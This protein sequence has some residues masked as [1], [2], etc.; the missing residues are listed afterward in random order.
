MR[1]QK[2]MSLIEVL[3]ALFLCSIVILAAITFISTSFKNTSRNKDKDFATQKAIAMLEE[4][5]SI[6]ESQGDDTTLLDSYDDGAVESEFLTIRRDVT[7]PLDPASGNVTFPAINPSQPGFKYLRRIMVQRLPGAQSSSIRLVNVKVFVNKDDDKD[8]DPDLLAEVAGVIQTV[9][10]NFP[11]TQVY[12]VYLLALENVPGWWVYMSN[13]IPFVQNAMADLQARNPGLEFRPHWITKLSY[14]RD[15]EYVPYVNRTASS[16]AASSGN[17]VY[18]YPGLMPGGSSVQFYYPPT[19]FNA[20]VAVDGVVTNGYNLTANPHPYALAD[21]FN[22]AMRYPDE[23]A[24]FENRVAA[25]QEVDGTPTFR[26]LLERMATRPADFRNAIFINLH[27]E[28][29]PFPPIRNYSDPAKEPVTFPNVRVVTHSERLRYRNDDTLNLRVYGYNTNAP[30]DENNPAGGAGAPGSIPAPVDGVDILSN[31]PITITIKGLTA[32]WVPAGIAGDQIQAIKGG[33]DLEAPLNQ[34]DP[35][36]LIVA[37]TTPAATAYYTVDNSGP[38]VVIELFNTPLRTPAWAIANQDATCSGAVG[39]FNCWQG[40]RNGKRLYGMEYIPSP[41]EDFT[42]DTTATPVPGTT[43]PVPT[44]TP[45]TKNLTTVESATAGA[46][47]TRGN[48]A[49]NTARWIF[50]IPDTVLPDDN[51]ITIETR[52]G[53]DPCTGLLYA[54]P[55][56]PGCTTIPNE[57]TNLSRTYAWRGDDAHIFGD[58]AVS[59]VIDP[60]LPY[61]ERY[62]I[63]GDPRHLPYVDSKQPH[64]SASFVLHNEDSLGMGYNRYFDDFHMGTNNCAVGL[65]TAGANCNAAPNTINDFWPGWTYTIGGQQYGLKSDANNNNDGW[66]TRA[67]KAPNPGLTTNS[68]LEIDEHRIFQTYRSILMKVQSVYTT[69]SGFSYYYTGI[70]NEI[71]YDTANGFPNSIP[72]NTKPFTGVA[73]TGF[74]DSITG[75]V[76]YIREGANG[77]GSNYWWG[78]SWLG[79]LWP[80]SMYPSTAPGGGWVTTGNLPT[81][82]TASTFVRTNRAQT[83]ATVNN[84]SR[85]RYPDGTDLT[86]AVRRPQEEGSATFF[87]TGSANSTFHHEFRDNTFGT[88]LQAGTDIGTGFNYPIPDNV[89]LYRPFSITYNQ[90]NYN[91]NAFLQTVYGPA[92]TTVNELQFYSHAGPTL[93]S[94]LI[95]VDNPTNNDLSFVVVNGLSMT[96]ASGTAFISRW[97]MLSLIESFLR[98][99][100]YNISGSTPGPN[101]I[102]QVPRIAITQPS[103]SMDPDLVNDPSDLEIIWNAEWLRWN[104]DKYIEGTAS[105]YPAGYAENGSDLTFFVLWTNDPNGGLGTWKYANDNTTVATPGVRGPSGFGIAGALPLINPYS[106]TWSTPAGAFPQGNYTVR[107][108]AYR[109][110]LPL[111]YSYHQYRVFIRR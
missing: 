47:C 46:V 36:S 82:N 40:L 17:L 84:N 3:I 108:E 43:T 111:H 30:N 105:P 81:G 1:N 64:E 110:D 2:G 101:H 72:V 28:L 11:P 45:F 96:T 78:L 109:D 21:Q 22:N 55:D 56:Q 100:L 41:L 71:G 106:F 42:L 16:T 53:N 6:L 69:M 80:D 87:W 88:L 76:K 23:L 31:T 29:F 10:S 13:L 49:K 95:S 7:D 66:D 89:P 39:T 27:G 12:D 83:A 50:T 9:A 91:P 60:I 86:Q 44:P 26:I 70:G 20:R 73:G 104:G 98:G 103:D 48:C 77:A 107:V 35:Y 97:S 57:P 52:I 63:L 38:D 68:F 93:G 54:D 102:E 92:L 5:K 32:D 59:P 58:P 33:L 15:Q 74:E 90:V 25:G 24:Y 94:A 14:G 61:T 37:N 62:Q 4:L 34:R 75:S 85:F 18:W 67:D 65:G 79:E 8:G 19:G 51:V 99:G